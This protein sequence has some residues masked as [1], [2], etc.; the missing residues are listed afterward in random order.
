PTGHVFLNK[1]G[2]PYSKDCLVRKMD[3]LRD[4]AE[5]GAKGGE[6]I[7]L[8]SNRHTFGTDN[9]GKVSDIELAEVMGHTET[10]MTRRYVH[11]SAGRLRDIQRRLQARPGVPGNAS[12]SGN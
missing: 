3:R 5:I 12:A 11:S 6:Q 8:Y 7:V 9:A 4:R 1:L 2:Q 10:R